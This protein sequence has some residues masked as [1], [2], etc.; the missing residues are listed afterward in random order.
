MTILTWLLFIC[1]ADS[2]AEQ[3]IFLESLI[4]LFLLTGI[5]YCL[6]DM[7]DLARMLK[8]NNKNETV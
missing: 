3:G 7:D 8:I 2:I 6:V 5:C 4:I 1:G